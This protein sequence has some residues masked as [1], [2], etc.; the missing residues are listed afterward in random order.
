MDMLQHRKTAARGVI[1]AV[2][3][4]LVAASSVAVA[5]PEP[6]G[7]V[8][9]DVN[10]SKR[11]LYPIAVP[12]SPEGDQG[13]AKEIAAVAS[14]DLSVAGVFKVIDPQSFLADLRAEGIG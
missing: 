11:T 3:V 10:A 12:M 1:L 7:G 6:K 8:V 4:G 2:I 5:Q 13:V 9:I 14:F